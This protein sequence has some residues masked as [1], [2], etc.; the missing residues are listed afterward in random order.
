MATDLEFPI[1]LRMKAGS[2]L[3]VLVVALFMFGYGAY[4]VESHSMFEVPAPIFGYISATTFGYIAAAIGIALL[5][6]WVHAFVSDRP[7][8]VLE[9]DGLVFTPTFGA[10]RRLTWAEIA[11]F[12]VYSDRY[13][14]GV[15]VLTRAGKRVKIP[16]LEGSADDLH[17]LLLR[18]ADD[19]S[20]TAK[21][22]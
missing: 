11:A 18:C 8:L 12:T 3:L 19:A 15:E 16:A 21:P 7:K 6:A 10:A 1:V 22:A 2:K 5:I 20:A 14:A 9:A 4:L 17:D 13:S